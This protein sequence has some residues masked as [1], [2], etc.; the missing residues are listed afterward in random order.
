M[1][2]LLKMRFILLI[3]FSKHCAL[4]T[5]LKLDRTKLKVYIYKSYNK[6]CYCNAGTNAGSV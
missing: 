2:V 5:M 1:G 4:I 3:L 6:R